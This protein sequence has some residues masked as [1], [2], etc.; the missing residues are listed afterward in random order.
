MTISVFAARSSNLLLYFSYMTGI[1]EKPK[2]F[3]LKIRSYACESN[4]G[5]FLMI[6]NGRIEYLE[7]VDYFLKNNSQKIDQQNK[8]EESKLK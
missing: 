8:D 4:S 3:N 1:I 5:D 6:K 7:K 2:Y